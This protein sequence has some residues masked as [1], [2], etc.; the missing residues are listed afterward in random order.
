MELFCVYFK[1][2]FEKFIIGG[3]LMELTEWIK[4]C[5]MEQCLNDDNGTMPD[6][7]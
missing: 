1:E 2:L 5:K 3:I 4:T 7:K 6:D